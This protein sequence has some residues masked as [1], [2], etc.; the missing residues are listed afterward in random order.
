LRVDAEGEAWP[1]VRHDLYAP[2]D[3]EVIAVHRDHNQRVAEGETIVAL[4]SA[5]LELEMQR[6]R[7]EFQTTQKKLLAIASARLRSDEG[8]TAERY[9][10][11]L[12]AEEQELKQLLT[13]ESRQLG[14]VRRQQELLH[15]QSPIAGR[16]LTWNPHQKLERRPVERGQRLVTVADESG[17]WILELTVP[18]RQARHLLAAAETDPQPLVVE[19]S[20]AADRSRR[21][22]GRV[23][24]VAKRTEVGRDRGSRVRVTAEVDGEAIAHLRPGAAVFAKIDCGRGSLG[25]VWLD[26]AVQALRGWWF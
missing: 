26:G 24:N 13:S 23:K 16:L 8:A 1:Q 19:F 10:G 18:E 12:A 22:T 17:P 25:Y 15:V 20:L 4:R 21:F 9:P 3:G 2:L 6:V 11:Q 7:G 5:D 14:L